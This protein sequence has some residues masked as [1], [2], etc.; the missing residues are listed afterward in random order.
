MGSQEPTKPMPTEPLD[1]K[2][3]VFTNAMKFK[4]SVLDTISSDDSTYE[5]VL[6][7]P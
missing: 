2:N 1:D 3:G 5:I 7:I 4:N 6:F